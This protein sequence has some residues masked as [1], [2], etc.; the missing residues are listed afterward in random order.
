LYE[1]GRELNLHRFRVSLRRKKIDAG[2][3]H[4]DD[5]EIEIFAVGK[6]D[7]WKMN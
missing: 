3:R 7:S 1:T 5:G 6:K 4:Y 2:A